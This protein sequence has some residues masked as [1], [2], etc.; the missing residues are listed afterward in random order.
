MVMRKFY[1]NKLWRSKLADQREQD[2]AIVHLIPLTD[3]EY[4]DE[5]ALK[6][7]EE[8]DEVYEAES[9]DVMKEE[10]VDILE[11]IDCLLALHNISHDEI[12]ALKEKK[13]LEFGSYTNRNLVEYVEYPDGSKEAL[14]CLEKSEKY[15]E[16]FE[17][18]N[19]TLTTEDACCSDDE[20]C[21]I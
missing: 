11:A 14:E 19:Q 20:E 4:G 17:D 1:Q 10:I 3:A 18:E 12:A 13:L 2:G 15:P 8:A 7:I 5:L 16:L 9:M 21:S 6:L